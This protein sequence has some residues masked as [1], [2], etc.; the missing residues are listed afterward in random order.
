M[1]ESQAKYLSDARAQLEDLRNKAAILEAEIEEHKE[2]EIAEYVEEIKATCLDMG[3]EVDEVV[4]RLMPKAKP[5]AQ[6]KAKRKSNGTKTYWQDSEGRI[7]RGKGAM[8]GWMF[9]AIKASGR[10]PS[11]EG[12]RKAYREANMRQVEG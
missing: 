1:S 7:D 5:S 10:D 9:D 8:P 6:E 11:A 12:A 4:A 3:F 2:E